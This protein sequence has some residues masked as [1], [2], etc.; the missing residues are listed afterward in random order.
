MQ[1]NRRK[2]DPEESQAHVHRRKSDADS[3]LHMHNRLDDCEETIKKLLESNR[4][5]AE[6]L[7][8]LTGEL[9]RVAEVLEAWNNAKGFILTLKLIS[10]GV[11]VIAPIVAFVVIIW[12]FIKTGKWVTGIE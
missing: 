11:K 10:G 7:Q 4:E 6:L 12:V 3:I 1:N 2:T 9:S 8:S 5:T